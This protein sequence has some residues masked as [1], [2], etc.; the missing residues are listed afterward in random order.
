M[1]HV[2]Q[3]TAAARNAF[4]YV[5]REC[6]RTAAEGY[7][8]L[9]SDNGAK[10]GIIPESANRNPRY[11]IQRGKS[12]RVNLYPESEGR[13]PGGGIRG[14]IRVEGRFLEVKKKRSGVSFLEINSYFCIITVCTSDS[15][16]I[17]PARAS[18][19]GIPAW[20]IIPCLNGF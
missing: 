13:N 15:Y 20:R 4:K 16:S 6:Y 10:I 3:S 19:I 2:L 5:Q 7:A 1:F 9:S 12:G 8:K 14:L 11:G 18:W 17:R